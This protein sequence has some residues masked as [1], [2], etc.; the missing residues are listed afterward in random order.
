MRIRPTIV[1][2]LDRVE[3]GTASDACEAAKLLSNTKGTRIISALDRILRSGDKTYR[4][5]AAAYALRWH[6]DPKAALSLLACAV[7]R[8]QEDS[9]R[10]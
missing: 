10:G 7:D 5:E 4:R 1:K 8:S 6:A 2:L 3:R 9:V